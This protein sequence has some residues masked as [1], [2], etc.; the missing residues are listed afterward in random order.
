[1]KLRYLLIL[2]PILTLLLCGCQSEPA[3]PYENVPR[4]P[5]AGE[6][7]PVYTIVR[8]D[9]ADADDVSA[10]TTLR[11]YL[12][13]GGI[14]MNITTDWEKNP[15]SDYEIVVGENLRA[16]N[17]PG[18]TVDPKSL[19]E[20]G[21]MVK[22]SG[23]R[24][25]LLGGSSAA[26]MDAVEYF[27]T[28]F[29]GYTGS[30]DAAQPITAI[31]IPETY[32]FLQKQTYALT[33]ITVDGRN[34]QE[35]AITWTDSF[36]SYYAKT[37]GG[38]LQDSLYKSC[39]IW[40]DVVAAGEWDGPSLQLD[41]DLS[42]TSGTFQIYVENG[43]LICSAALPE[44]VERGCEMFIRSVIQNAEGE[45]TMDTDYR[46][47]YDVSTVFYKDF[48]AVGDGVTNDIEAIY[49]AHEYANSRGLP[50]KAEEGATYYISDVENS[51]IIRTDT[52]WTGASFILDDRAVPYDKRSQTIFTVTA[53][54]S[55]YSITDQL[56]TLSKGQDNI[57]LTF[58]EDSLVVLTDS[59]TKRY[60][61]WGVNANTGSNQTDLIVVDKDGNIDQRAPLIW[62]Y[63]TITDAKVIPMDMETLT[64]KGG[65]FTTITVET[66]PDPRYYNRGINIRRSNVVVDGL[67][68]YVENEG[69]DGVSY[70]GILMVQDCANV[71]V[72]NCVFT[73]HRTH[74]YLL[75]NG[76]RFSQGTYDITPSRA[77][78]LT[79][80]NCTQ[81]VDILD[82]A[83]WGV[84]G[85]NFCKNI[86]LKNC[87][88]SRFDAHQGVAN[89]TIIGSTLGHQGLNA[90]G[91]GTLLV[92]DSTLYGSSFIN[93]R[94]DYGSTWEG[95]LIIRNCTWIP[96]KG[97]TLTGRYSVIYGQYTPFHDFGYPCYMPENITVEGLYIDDS[98]AAD[99]Y[100]GIYLFDK[101]NGDYI[102]GAYAKQVEEEG[103]PYQVTKEI[104]ISGFSSA[105]GKDWNLTANK[106]L[107]RNLTV[108]D[109]DP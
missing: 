90:I 99:T 60:I 37:T 107:F 95:D 10:A 8:G 94:S 97:Q 28:Q 46:F 72:R 29:C 33:G 108:N 101:F 22:V 48:G 6:G 31:S 64:I 82:T 96:N 45:L 44:D 67:T 43:N 55:T 81:T 34:L 13:N 35:F 16:E 50:V 2:L 26:T 80:E 40:L 85:S 65:T 47:T 32:E 75:E 83:Y 105:S 56:T 25:Y 61:R 57:G 79:F 69:V 17:D 24:I 51:V 98:N 100:P 42:D 102:N 4:L 103:Y 3:D 78:N 38:Y 71:T 70:G 66:E 5:I 84:M 52:D 11:N 36:G 23:K 39:G 15:V 58:P 59:N 86:I 21:F 7:A 87:S 73:P 93:L 76:E 53:D 27:L 62:D 9:S 18:M 63:E 19:G 92:E 14:D 30:M 74:W 49:N 88:F 12:K 77:V 106:Y 68:H 91:M 54:K 109:L 89:V 104:T 41:R 1:M 20:E